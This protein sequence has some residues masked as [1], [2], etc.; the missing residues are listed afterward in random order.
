MTA[1]LIVLSCA[2]LCVRFQA[3]PKML[4]FKQDISFGE[5]LLEFQLPGPLRFTASASVWVPKL[6]CMGNVLPRLGALTRL[7]GEWGHA[8]TVQSISCAVILPCCYAALPGGCR[9]AP[10]PA[11]H[12]K[13]T[14]WPPFIDKLAWPR[15][16]TCADMPLVM[17]MGAW[18]LHTPGRSPGKS[19]RPM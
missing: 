11:A 1:H 8:V 15:I 2:T 16:R 14:V 6:A 10:L 7:A 17:S 9:Q 13:C 12:F 18:A 19:S 3:C 5:E 4:E